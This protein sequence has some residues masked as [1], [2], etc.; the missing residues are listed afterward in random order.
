[1]DGRTSGKNQD[2]LGPGPQL[3]GGGR[4]CSH[5]VLCSG[6]HILLKPQPPLCAGARSHETQGAGFHPLASKPGEERVALGGC[7]CGGLG[8]H[9]PV[10]DDQGFCSLMGVGQGQKEG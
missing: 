6:H 4:I 5:H 3:K 1:M 10:Q 9:L 2:L 8:H 7:V